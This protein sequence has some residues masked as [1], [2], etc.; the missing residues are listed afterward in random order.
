MMELK[1][2]NPKSSEDW[3]IAAKYDTVEF[4]DEEDI[5]QPTEVEIDGME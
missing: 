4:T 3:A 1:N 2:Y 5:N